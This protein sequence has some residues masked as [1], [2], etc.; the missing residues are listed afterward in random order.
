MQESPRGQQRPRARIADR[1]EVLRWLAWP[2][3][4]AAAAAAIYPTTSRAQTLR[5][6]KPSVEKMYDFALSHGMSFRA[7]PEVIDRDAGAGHLVRLGG[8]WDYELTNGV[9]WPYVTPETRR[10]V[11]AFAE[12]YSAVCAAPLVVTSASRPLS[13]QPR[14]ANPHSVHPAGIAIDLRRP[15]G[16]PCLE[17]TRAAL[18]E[19]EN[20][21]IIEATEERHPVHFHV[22]V[23][24]RRGTDVRLP[25]LR[26]AGQDPIAKRPAWLAV[27]RQYHAPLGPVV[28]EAEGEEDVPPSWD[29]RA[30]PSRPRSLFARRLYLPSGSQRLALVT[31]RAIPAFLVREEVHAGDVVVRA[32]GSTPSAVPA[33]A[34]A[35]ATPRAT[36]ASVRPVAAPRA[37]AP[38]AG[39]SHRVRRGETLWGIARRYGTSVDALVASNRLDR[40]ARIQPGDVLTVPT[41]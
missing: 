24:A 23:L 2:L 34:A 18:I 14:N 9:G 27:R 38:A 6:S 11:E 33:R 41:E 13:R 22:A 28:A 15:R 1:T 40:A 8:S 25:A 10:F 20:R 3:A 16:G 29:R 26:V 21:G 4:L 36:V 17:W 31:D 12:Q 19:L 39:R 32:V 35:S 7:T 37:G 5:G 30:L